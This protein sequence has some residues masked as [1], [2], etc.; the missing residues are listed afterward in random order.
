[1]ELITH[2][3]LHFTH[4]RAAVWAA[5]ADVDSYRTWWPWL[6]R[7]EAEALATDRLWRCVVRPPLPYTV[8]FAIAFTRVV[9]RSVVEARVTGDVVGDA[10]LTLRDAD[11]GCEVVVRSDLRP[12]SPFLRLL[13]RT[14]P[15]VARYGHD[16]ILGTGARQ[17]ERRALLSADARGTT[18]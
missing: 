13:A 12:D 9:E 16:W 4:D 5:M 3:T 6:R 17:F 15:G 1:M 7:F 18:T 8:T 2:Q 14:V 11:A 10:E